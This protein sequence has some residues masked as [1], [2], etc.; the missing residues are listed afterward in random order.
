MLQSY[1]NSSFSMK[2]YQEHWEVSSV[3]TGSSKIGGEGLAPVNLIMISQTPSRRQESRR[4]NP[5]SLLSPP[6]RWVCPSPIPDWMRS[7][8]GH[9]ARGQRRRQL[10][11]IV[12]NMYSGLTVWFEPNFYPLIL[13]WPWVRY[14]NTQ[15]LSAPTCK[16][17]DKDSIYSEGD[18]KD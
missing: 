14:L 16:K 3:S 8:D 11:V 6:Q 12:M 15:G 9:K 1:M 13:V 2:F 7:G 5:S 10:N 18:W 17:N 4:S